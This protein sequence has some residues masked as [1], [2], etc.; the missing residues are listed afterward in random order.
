MAVS[1]RRKPIVGQ[2]PEGHRDTQSWPLSDAI[3]EFLSEPGQ[4]VLVTLRPTGT[5]HAVPV[6]FTW[7]S[8]AR[9]ARVMT[10]GQSKKARNLVA[11]PGSRVALCQRDEV[12]SWVTLEGTG[13]VHDDPERLAEGARRYA[14]RYKKEWLNPPGAAVIEIAV[15]VVMARNV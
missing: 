14:E 5:I 11:A 12:S 10:G 6:S 3:E 7:D 2:M 9:L 4:A 1:N 15:D 8:E 13:T